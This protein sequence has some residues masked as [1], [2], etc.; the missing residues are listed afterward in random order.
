MESWKPLEWRRLRSRRQH[1]LLRRPCS[2]GDSGLESSCPPRA[3]LSAR[4][5]GRAATTFCALI[6]AVA[7]LTA[8]VIPPKDKLTDDEKIEILRNLSAEFAKAKTYLPR[9][10]K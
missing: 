10:K 3:R 4:S 9:S 2:A 8:A 6:V 7:P 1:S 5:I